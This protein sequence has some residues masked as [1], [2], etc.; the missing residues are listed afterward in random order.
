MRLLSPIRPQR[1]G[2]LSV[3]FLLA[4]PLGLLLGLIAVNRLLLTDL[5]GIQE[6]VSDAAALAAAQALVDDHHLVGD[7]DPIEAMARLVAQQYADLNPIEGQKLQFVSPSFPEYDDI[8]FERVPHPLDPV[9]TSIVRSVRVHGRNLRSRDAGVKLF[10]Y[11]LYP[12][13]RVDLVTSA[14][15]LLD[16]AVVG[17]RPLYGRNVPLAPIAL[18]ETKWNRFIE[19]QIIGK[20]FNALPT[21]TFTVGVVEAIPLKIG[22]TDL[23]GV[24]TQL[25]A[26]VTPAEIGAAPFNGEFI[27]PPAQTKATPAYLAAADYAPLVAPLQALQASGDARVW[28]I[29][30]GFDQMTLEPLVNRFVAARVVNVTAVTNPMTMTTDAIQLTLRPTAFASPMIVTDT[31]QTVVNPY[32]SRVRL[33]P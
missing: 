28:P 11:P 19:S 30:S 14:A 22:T 5:R 8:L 6:A 17:V 12:L 15:G 32:L 9:N 24:A 10:G 1:T 16:R 7:L 29:F 21:G 33:T 3:W 25:S 18:D 31:A 27:V 20:A 2:A 26:G 4:L 23:N 13:A